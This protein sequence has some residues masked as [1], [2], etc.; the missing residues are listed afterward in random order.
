MTAKHSFLGLVVGLL[1]GLP[2]SAAEVRGVIVKAD[3]DKNQLTIEGRG[4]G[5]RG[6]I[7]TF[8]IDKETQIQAGHKPL[9]MADLI[10]G[11]RVRI[12]YELQGDRRVAL[13]ITLLG[14]QPGSALPA[15]PP[16]TNGTNLSGILRRVSFSEREIVVISSDAKG[17]VEVETP[18]WVPEDTKITRDQKAIP[19]EELKEGDAVLVQIEKRNGKLAAK[20]IL[21][22]APGNVNKPVEPGQNNIQRIRQALKM[23]D[24]VLQMMEQKQKSP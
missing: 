7:M 16:A 3:G 4:L 21:L 8:Q 9:K 22:G 1:L 23:I 15:V 14:L 10:T 18:V 24:I 19:F 20:A 12:T 2:A 5:V 11:R 6:A 17:N 13:V